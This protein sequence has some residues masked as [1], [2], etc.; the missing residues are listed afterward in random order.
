MRIK[1]KYL[2]LRILSFPFK[3]ALILFW[4]ILFSVLLCYN[5]VLYSSDEIYFFMLD[6]EDDIMKLIKQ[7]KKLIKHLDEV[8]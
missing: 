8:L 1:R 6:E 2:L 3:L 5:W 4:N 7:N